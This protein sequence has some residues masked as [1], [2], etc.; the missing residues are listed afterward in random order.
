MQVQDD[1]GAR[2]ARGGQGAPAERRV[3][4]VG[5]HDAGAGAPH[6]GRDLGGS[7]ATAEQARRRARATE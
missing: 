4:V 7:Q 1:A 6:G 5:V 3:D 2:A